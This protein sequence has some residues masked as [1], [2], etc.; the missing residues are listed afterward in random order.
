MYFDSIRCYASYASYCVTINTVFLEKCVRTA[1]KTML[2]DR[3][4]QKTLALLDLVSGPL[5]NA[6]NSSVH[7]T[8]FAAEPTTKMKSSKAIS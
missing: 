6:V 8:E 1:A 7:L 5:L 4:N 2:V 3:K